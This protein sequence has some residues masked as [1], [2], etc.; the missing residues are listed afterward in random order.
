MVELAQLSPGRLR[1]AGIAFALFGLSW[2]LGP[3]FSFV[4]LYGEDG[5]GL[6]KDSFYGVITLGPAGLMLV[7]YGATLLR[8]AGK[9]GCYFR[10]GP[11]GL[12]LR[13]GI[14]GIYSALA[15]RMPL[16]LIPASPYTFARRF[17]GQ[18]A[19]WDGYSFL[20]RFRWQDIEAIECA[21]PNR[22][23]NIKLR[24]GEELSVARYH[25]S[26]KITEIA[27]RIEQAQVGSHE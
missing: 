5:G 14:D 2:I 10:A 23:L 12:A 17:P 9:E 20:Y 27:R 13:L 19:T 6:D 22:S 7:L 26:E 11:E 15:G 25:F 4:H 8:Q 1:L 24:S 21:G 18:W 3:A 16:R